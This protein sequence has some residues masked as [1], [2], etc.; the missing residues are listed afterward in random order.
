MVPDVGG[1]QCVLVGDDHM[2]S[3]PFQCADW[4]HINAYVVW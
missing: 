4:P 2:N 1:G 3:E